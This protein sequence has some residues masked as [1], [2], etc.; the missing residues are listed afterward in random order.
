M[1]E[2][3]FWFDYKFKQIKAMHRTVNIVNGAR[4]CGKTFAFKKDS[5]ETF[6]KDGGQFVYMRR[7][8]KEL[9][10]AKARELFFPLALREMYPEHEL[11]YKQGF[12][13]IDGKIAGFPFALNTPGAGKSI[14]YDNVASVC[15]DEYIDVNG[16]YLNDE[17]KLFNE[18]LI[19]IGRFRNPKY[20]LIA[21]N[22]TWLNPYFLRWKI[23]HPDKGKETKLGKTWS[24][25]L[26]RSDKYKKFMETTPVGAFL[27]ECDPDHFEYAFGNELLDDDTDFIEQHPGRAKYVFTLSSDGEELGVWKDSCYYISRSVDPST[28]FRLDVDTKTLKKNKLRFRPGGIF[29]AFRTALLSDRVFF[30]DMEIKAKALDILKLII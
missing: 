8:D 15:Y 6:L 5:V 30:E 26:P 7:Y 19:T 18:A 16:R 13:E 17:V 10:D 21:N 24:F 4:G 2:P 22:L 23:T 29:E 1:E 11:V 20:W 9:T 12:Y 28:F 25:T 27:L 3:K 14:E